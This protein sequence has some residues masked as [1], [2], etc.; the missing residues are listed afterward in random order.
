MVLDPG[1]SLRRVELL[2]LL[3]QL[4]PWIAK[5]DE[6]VMQAA[7]SCATA[8]CLMQ[9]AGVG[10]VTALAFVLTIPVNFPALAP[11]DEK[12]YSIRDDLGEMLSET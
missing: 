7:E 1:A 10:P 11:S 12:D 9:Q 5:L 3:D 6:A 4:D 8:V 2:Q